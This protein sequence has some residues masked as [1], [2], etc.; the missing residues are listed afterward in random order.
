MPLSPPP[1]RLG[2]MENLAGVIDI[3]LGR[4]SGRA[5]LDLSARGIGWSFGGLALAGLVDMSALSILYNVQAPQISSQIGKSF[6]IF[7]HIFIALIGYA[8]SILALYLL[9][10]TPAEQRNFPAAI[11]AH[12]WAA[13][14]VSLA[15]LPLIIIATSLGGPVS[16]DGGNDLLTLVSVFWIGVLIFVGVRLIGLSLEVSLKK[17]VMRFVITPAVSL[18]TTE[19]L[20]NLIGLTPN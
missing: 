12:N 1:S 16:P 15:F 20:E 3:M 5:R 6:F 13:P 19:G 18:V 9:C 4:P 8:A 17:A 2:L 10:R 7:G 11:A 14:I